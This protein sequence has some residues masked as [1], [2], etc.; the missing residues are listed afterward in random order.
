[1]KSKTFSSAIFFSLFLSLSFALLRL[2]LSLIHEK[3]EAHSLDPCTHAL[4]FSSSHQLSCCAKRQ[5]E[6]EKE[7][8]RATTMN[9]GGDGDDEFAPSSSFAGPRPGFYFGSGSRGV[10]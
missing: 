4:F 7:K 3:V 8:E 5:K 10:G 2:S 9:G 6:K 1:M